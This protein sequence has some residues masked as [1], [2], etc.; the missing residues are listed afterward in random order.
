MTDDERRFFSDEKLYNVSFEEFFFWS[1]HGAK[2]SIQYFLN[3]K[4]KKIKFLQI[5]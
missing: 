2:K 3:F 1:M 4:K 5:V